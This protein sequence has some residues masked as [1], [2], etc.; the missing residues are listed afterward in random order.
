M[1]RQTG[2]FLR[3]HTKIKL[4]EEIKDKRTDVLIICL[5]SS[6]NDLRTLCSKYQSV[7]YHSH[8]IFIDVNKTTV[9]VLSFVVVHKSLVVWKHQLKTLTSHKTAE[10]YHN[11]LVFIT[12]LRIFWAPL[13]MMTPSIF[14]Y[15]FISD[16][17]YKG[18]SI[19]MKPCSG[20]KRKWW[21]DIW[22]FILSS[23]VTAAAVHLQ[24]CEKTWGI[25]IIIISF[26][27]EAEYVILT[28]CHYK[29]LWFK[30]ILLN[31]K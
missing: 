4:M 27:K 16:F 10:N 7:I 26:K 12:F 19:L 11:F 9:C 5:L 18:I 17:E 6:S 14:F 13:Q 29:I 15:V 8:S 31:K 25:I 2:L 23:A 24:Y 22:M 28:S 30:V 20:E 1:Q 3:R 21:Q